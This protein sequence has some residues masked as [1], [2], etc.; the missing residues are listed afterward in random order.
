[1][2]NFL[3]TNPRIYSKVLELPFTKKSTRIQR[4]P[5]IQRGKPERVRELFI[6]V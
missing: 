5:S 2:I 4:S 3:A 6:I 1:M